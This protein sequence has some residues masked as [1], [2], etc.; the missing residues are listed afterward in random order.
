[1]SDACYD[2]AYGFARAMFIFDEVREVGRKH[3]LRRT[4]DIV[5]PFLVVRLTSLFG[6][7]SSRHDIHCAFE[8]ALVKCDHE[9]THPGVH[10]L[11]SCRSTD[12]RRNGQEIKAGRF[13][14]GLNGTCI[15]LH[16]EETWMP[17]RLAIH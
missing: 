13:I 15:I 2:E 12:E 5:G 9:S 16:W 8:R 10:L 11:A 4:K 6:R 17:F 3:R 7:N 14:V 1:M